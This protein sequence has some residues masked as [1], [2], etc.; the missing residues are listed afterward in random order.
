MFG[1]TIERAARG[2]DIH[3]PPQTL[4][5]MGVSDLRFGA[6]WLDCMVALVARLEM[7]DGEIFTLVVHPGDGIWYLDILDHDGRCAFETMPLIADNE[8][9]ARV[10]A[11]RVFERYVSHLSTDVR[12]MRPV[13]NA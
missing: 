4:D 13:G 2:F 6:G 9:H 1:I 8:G 10:I 11:V 3:I 12:F 7:D 5:M